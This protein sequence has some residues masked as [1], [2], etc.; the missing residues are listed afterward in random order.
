MT[1]GELKKYI[2]DKPTIHNDVVYVYDFVDGSEYEAD[3]DEF[4]VNDGEWFP[5]ITINSSSLEE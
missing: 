4:K 5:S 2:E 3:I 1:W